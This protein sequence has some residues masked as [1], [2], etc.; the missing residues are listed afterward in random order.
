[1]QVELELSFLGTVVWGTHALQATVGAMSYCGR[2][3]GPLRAE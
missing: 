3:V 1:M 2:K